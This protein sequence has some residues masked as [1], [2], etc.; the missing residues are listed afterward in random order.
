MKKQIIYIHIGCHKTGTTSIQ[1]GLH[2]QKKELQRLGF[3]YHCFEGTPAANRY[4]TFKDMKEGFFI[5]NYDLLIKKLREENKEKVIISAEN[6][7]FI[8]SKSELRTLKRRLSK[9]FHEIKIITYLRRQDSHLVSHHQEGSKPDRV[10]E[11]LLWGYSTEALPKYT[12]GHEKYLNY[13][14]RLS[15]WSDVFGIGNVLIRVF[16]KDKLYRG[17]SFLDF[18]QSINLPSENFS[19]PTK[20]NKSEGSVKSKYG[21]LINKTI[22]NPDIKR[23]LYHSLPNNPEKHLPTA[24]A[25][26]DYYQKYEKS[27]KNLALNF[28]NSNRPL[29]SDN[30]SMYSNPELSPISCEDVLT[31]LLE[32]CNDIFSSFSVEALRDSA[33]LLEGKSPE[34]SLA[35]ME[36]AKTLRPDGPLI[37]RKISHYKRSRKG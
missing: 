27:N 26:E 33:I 8:F 31:T 18:I 15:M 12:P 21:H 32:K 3:S 23:A 29:F 24:S 10:P 1:I 4:L 13:Y 14:Q 36:M 22:K 35:L 2:S 34:L 17:D 19:P 6:F 9:E 7:S 16:E 30:F 20:E 5:K 37:N 25:A 11:E 28:C